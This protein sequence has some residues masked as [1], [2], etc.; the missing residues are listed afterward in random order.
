[1][2]FLKWQE[3]LCKYDCIKDLRIR[4]IILYYPNGSSVI[5]WVLKAENLSLAEVSRSDNYERRPERYDVAGERGPQ[6]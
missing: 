5:S 2:C 3:R 6:A 4:K 1:M